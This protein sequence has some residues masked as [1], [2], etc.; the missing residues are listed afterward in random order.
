MAHTVVGVFDSSKEAQTAVQHL[1]NSG[2]AED[3]IDVTLQSADDELEFDDAMREDSIGNFFR[4]LFGSEKRSKEYSDYARS[5]SIVTVHTLNTPDAEKAADILDEYGAVNLD[6][7][8]RRHE[9][10]VSNANPVSD[11]EKAPQPVAQTEDVLAKTKREVRA[12]KVRNRSRIIA[13]AV[14]E[15]LRL[16]EV[17]VHADH[18]RVDRIATEAKENINQEAG[19]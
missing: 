16:R 13:R 14:E 17:R 4:S 1:I 5:G 15:R 6:E 7:R 19:L 12:E 8:T 18:A 2:F 9:N 3:Y 10:A 11:K